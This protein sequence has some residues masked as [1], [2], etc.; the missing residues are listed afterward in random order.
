MTDD[1]YVR[2]AL[3]AWIRAE[4]PTAV[5]VYGG[6]VRAGHRLSAAHR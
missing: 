6:A 2:E 1:L 5:E 4:E 3:D